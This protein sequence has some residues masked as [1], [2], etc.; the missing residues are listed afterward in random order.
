MTNNIVEISRN[1]INNIENIDELV[2][3]YFDPI[4]DLTETAGDIFTP[5]KAIH[6]LYTLNKKRKFKNI[7]KFYAES[8]KNC[9]FNI[10]DN[11]DRLKNYLK[12]EKNF[13]FLNEVIDNAIN[14]KSIYGANLL[15][16]FA[17]QILSKEM[18]ISYKELII[19]DGIKE[20][21]DIE[22][23]CFVRIYSVADLSKIVFLEQLTELKAFTFFC[24]LTIERMIQLRLIEKNHHTYSDSD[25][26]SSF[27][28]TDIAE[29][30][31]YLIKDCNI[32]NDLLYYKF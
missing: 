16:Y 15:G 27:I 20:L 24:E 7:L 8:L 13:N 4:K 9:K 23:S 22:L 2:D 17:G 11:A 31:F 32:Y 5:I 21:N 19:I 6:S 12:N 30:I 1:I 28:S 26:N 29:D 10:I 14:S 25:K 18:N 3:S